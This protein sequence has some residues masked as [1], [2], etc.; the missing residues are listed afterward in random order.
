MG[1]VYRVLD[2]EQRTEMAL[3]T[4]EDLDPDK[5]Y[6]LKQEFRFLAGLH[7]PNLVRL[8]DLVASTSSVFY[9]MELV[10]GTELAQ[11]VRRGLGPGE[12]LD[13]P[14]MA[15][16]TAATDQLV[17]GLSY[18]HS[19]DKIHRDVK[20]SNVMVDGDGRVVLLDFGL[21]SPISAD[22]L[23]TTLG[24]LAGTLPYLPPERLFDAPP[25]PGGDWYAVGVMLYEMVT[26]ELPF[27]GPV[28]VMMRQKESAIPVAGERCPGLPP[29][30]D[31]L[32]SRLLA[33]HPRARAGAQDVAEAMGELG[34][35]T[36]PKLA[37]AAPPPSLFVGRVRELEALRTWHRDRPSAGPTVIHVHGLS[38]MG[39]SALVTRWAESL[40]RSVL[41]DGRCGP[42]ENVPF[43]ALD[44]VIDALS[45]HV[46]RLKS[47]GEQIRAPVGLRALVDL[48]P[49]L[50]RVPEWRHPTESGVAREPRERSRQGIQALVQLFGRLA[51]RQSLVVWVDDIQWG[52]RDSLPMLEALISGPLAPPITWIFSWRSED[53]DH[54]DALSAVR[55]LVPWGGGPVKTL[56]ITPLP[57]SER[58]MLARRM[59]GVGAQGLE[60]LA[61]ES[62]GS[63]FFLDQLV[64]LQW[65]RAARGERS[66]PL[67]LADVLEHRL[68]ELAPAASE[69]LAYLCLAGPLQDSLLHRLVRPHEGLLELLHGLRATC[70]IRASSRDGCDVI[71]PRHDR[72]R[73]VVVARLDADQKQVLH[74]H[75]AKAMA[76]GGAP[77]ERL[78]THLLAAG[79]PE[80]AALQAGRAAADAARSLAF[81]RAAELYALSLTLGGDRDRGGLLAARADALANAGRSAEAAPVFQE[82][83]QHLDDPEQ[84]WHARQQSAAHLLYS[85]QFTEG[86][87]AMAQLLGELGI[88]LPKRPLAAALGG[89]LRLL[90]AGTEL[91]ALP[92]GGPD[93]GRCRRVDA[94][95]SAARGTAMVEHLVGDALAVQALREALALGD[96]ER[97]IR[98]LG[99]EAVS[100]ANIGGGF[101]RKRSAAL[102]AQV[103]ALA[104][105]SGTPYDHAWRLTVEGACAFFEGR[106]E[107]ATVALRESSE[108]FR[109]ECVGASH[110]MNV[111]DVFLL[112]SLAWR[113]ELVEL[114]RILPGL[115]TQ[116]DARGDLYASVVLQLDQ[117]VMVDLARD[118]WTQAVVQADAAL[119]RWPADGFTSQHYHHV[120]GTTRALL[121]GGDGAG[122]WERIAGLWPT[123]K[124]AGF[125]NL[126]ALGQML[127]YLRARAAMAA[128]GAPGA[129]RSGTL[130]KIAA[131]DSRVLQKGK[132]PFSA[133]FAASLRACLAVASPGGDPERELIRALEGFEEAGMH[134]ARE[135]ARLALS[136]H[137]GDLR[138]EAQALDWFAQAEVVRPEG[139]VR[140]FLPGLV[141]G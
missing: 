131:A 38:G 11:H 138:T 42:H 12:A 118:N 126:E 106:W 43:K 74:G 122:A 124:K 17:Q 76:T 109:A 10:E 140:L 65:S 61:Q 54:S 97:A 1:V 35:T 39:K 5:L 117:N 29:A 13:T 73:E 98:P 79:D 2:D 40:R 132:L 20:P 92:E 88:H 67:R 60:E 63:P 105:Q 4:I 78:A 9:T 82:A 137:L 51:R 127:R 125:L 91:A 114:G 107:K 99:H 24:A 34:A 37:S 81:E 44:S 30:L 119:A 55:A 52:D 47:E 31:S 59:L 113:G 57:D 14:A 77:A 8:Y 16:L 111:A 46:I 100:L 33:P 32:I 58:L 134:L 36:R 86:R 62:G 112:G 135:T 89:R 104:A 136:W 64:R 53:R 139:M 25:D 120:K 70:L 103:T 19:H 110:E 71:E 93:P 56:E 129:D 83:A 68:S 94:L 26:G 85:G 95:W 3:K 102:R 50:A 22:Q 18:L 80:Q 123:L 45:H 69:L 133:P 48:F 72:I 141:V 116:A 130:R 49:V 23:D 75:L 6:R 66:G 121:Y 115:R 101:F 27:A 7:H 108:R 28:P 128:A 87:V 84:S 21:G 90:F 41:L 15:R 96:P